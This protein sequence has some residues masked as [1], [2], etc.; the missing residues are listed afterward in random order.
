MNGSANTP[1][2][3]SIQKILGLI[4]LILG[5]ALIFYAI[6]SSYNIFTGK[7]QPPEIFKT[8]GSKT[9][10]SPSKAAS[11]Q[12][13]AQKLIEEGLQQQLQTMLPADSLPKILNL[14][15]WSILAWILIFGGVQISG[16]GIN[17]LK[18]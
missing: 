16:L 9:A 8:T 11:P 15:S 4:I 6:F 2:G 13:Q 3:T 14:I 12:E 17:L 7:S 1:S 18:R 10:A 5:L